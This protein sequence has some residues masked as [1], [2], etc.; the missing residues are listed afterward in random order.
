MKLLFG[1]AT[2]V[3]AG[4]SLRAFSLVALGSGANTLVSEAVVELLLAVVFGFF[5]FQRV[6]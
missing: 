5:T 3:F 4:L 1:V 6:A 2:V